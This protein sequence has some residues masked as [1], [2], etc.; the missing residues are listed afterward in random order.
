M[1]RLAIT[2][3]TIGFMVLSSL[4]FS[5]NQS[6]KNKK[7]PSLTRK[8]SIPPRSSPSPESS[9]ACSETSPEAVARHE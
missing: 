1:N 5:D 6:D 2:G 7:K 8:P 3:V 4:L 9:N